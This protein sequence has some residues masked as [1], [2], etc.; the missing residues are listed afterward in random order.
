MSLEDKDPFMSLA[1]PRGNAAGHH[2]RPLMAG[3]WPPPPSLPSAP[4]DVPSLS[5]SEVSAP[6]GPPCSLAE[7]RQALQWAARPA[8]HTL[9]LPI[10]GPAWPDPGK[11]LLKEWFQRGRPSITG[12]P[13]GLPVAS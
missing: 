2:P 6:A 10:G 13:A 9:Y 8:E 12:I 7:H 4:H 5:G 11:D 3:A 1:W